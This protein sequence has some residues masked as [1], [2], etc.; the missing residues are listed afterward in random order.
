MIT[1][2]YIIKNEERW[3]W[4][5]IMSIIEYVDEILVYDTGSTDKTVEIVKSINSSKIKIKEFKNIDKNSFTELKQR[6]IEETKTEW[7][8]TIDGDE[9]WDENSI[10]TIISRI[11]N[12]PEN[13]IGAFCHYFEFVNDIYHYYMGHEQIIYPLNKKKEYG[14]Y[15]IRFIKKIPGLVCKNEYGQEGYFTSDGQEL[16]RNPFENFLW[17]HDIYYFHTRNLIRSSSE[18]KDNEVMLRVEKRHNCKI[19]E[20]PKIYRGININYPEVFDLEHPK[21]VPNIYEIY[22]K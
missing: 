11:K 15:T 21:I 9:I 22:K 5:S 19:G 14:W 18:E 7:I 20:I 10:K 6:Q 17:C 12:S 8:A 2:H 13:I 16:Q 3:I 4:Y 1:A